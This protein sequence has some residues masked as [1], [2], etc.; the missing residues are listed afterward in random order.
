[1]VGQVA[2]ADINQIQGDASVELISSCYL[3]TGPDGLLPVFM[4][5]ISCTDMRGFT[6]P[7]RNINKN[8]RLQFIKFLCGW[9]GGGRGIDS[10]SGVGLWS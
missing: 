8:E 2:V 1:M 7:P 10:N 3:P 6:V 4:F 5:Y 9:R